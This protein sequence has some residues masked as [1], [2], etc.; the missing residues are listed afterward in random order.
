MVLS[1]RVVAGMY[2]CRFLLLRGGIQVYL[3]LNG[4]GVRVRFKDSIV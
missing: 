3:G 2:S 4:G 1:A